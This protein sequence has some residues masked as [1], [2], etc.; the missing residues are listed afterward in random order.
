M[1]NES[2]KPMVVPSSS[3]PKD[4]VNPV[5][6]TNKT[7][8]ALSKSHQGQASNAQK[9]HKTNQSQTTTHANEQSKHAN[10]VNSQHSKEQVGGH[11][12]EQGQTF[13]QVISDT[14]NQQPSKSLSSLLA[15]QPELKEVL[16]S[17]LLEQYVGS[18]GEVFEEL[19]IFIQ[20]HTEHL[21]DFS[22]PIPAELSE[23]QNLLEPEKAGQ[24]A[25][26]MAS[27][28]GNMQKEVSGESVISVEER[29]D[30]VIDM[31]ELPSQKREQNL[32]QMLQ[33]QKDAL[34]LIKAE[35]KGTITSQLKADV[36][37]TNTPLAS[38]LSKI[39]GQPQENKTAGVAE[40]F[41]E[42]GDQMKFDSKILNSPS[43]LK[44][45]TISGDAFVK[46]LQSQ[47]Q[48]KNTNSN[49]NTPQPQIMVNTDNVQSNATNAQL[50]ASANVKSLQIDTPV[51]QG[52]WSKQFNDQVMWLSTQKIQ[53]AAI[54]LTPRDL[55]PVEINLKISNDVASIQFNSH[56]PQVR[57]L[58]EHALPKLREQLSEQGIQLSDADVNDNSQQ[59]QMMKNA[60]YNDGKGSHQM[61]NDFFREL[62][63]E[64]VEP[65]V[66]ISEIRQKPP[67]G[68]VDYFA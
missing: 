7:S 9:P 18:G 41:L 63:G 46:Q 32:D 23:M 21:A 12:E 53:A 37:P 45:G 35:E 3:G 57:E 30:E 20:S 5:S 14:M 50:N 29:G 26:V 62:S 55:G 4:S 56:S 65:E 10:K 61:Q 66:M 58:I 8:N 31:V 17:D 25:A 49:N 59:Q 60:N 27:L 24:E 19:E 36:V 11:N 64:G 54:K 1:L 15:V 42:D 44:E 51:G 22:Q 38:A 33:K 67:Q 13:S 43:S 47:M 39:A 6:S 48:A 68:L 52:Q 40:G 16:P 28:L 34:G 2:P